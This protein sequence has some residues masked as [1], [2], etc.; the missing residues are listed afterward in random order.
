[1]TGGKPQASNLKLQGSL[2]PQASKFNLVEADGRK[3]YYWSQ[4]AKR[5]D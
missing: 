3:L 1:M 4:I 5:K 2:K